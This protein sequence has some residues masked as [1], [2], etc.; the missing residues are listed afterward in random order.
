M[1]CLT[2]ICASPVLDVSVSVNSYDFCLA[3]LEGIVL[4]SPYLL[5]VKLLPRLQWVFPEVWGDGFDGNTIFSADCP[6][7]SLSYPNPL[8][9]SLHN[10][11]LLVSIF[12][13]ICCRKKCLPSPPQKRRSRKRKRMWG[14]E[15]INK[16]RKEGSQEEGN[17]RKGENPR[18]SRYCIRY[19]VA[20]CYWNRIL[21]S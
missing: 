16:W 2:N 17:G 13:P 19:L 10:V 18:F 4:V 9:L 11:W 3:N 21:F 15:K 1:Q 14:R 20:A 8:F 5:P 7:V 12:I 6:K